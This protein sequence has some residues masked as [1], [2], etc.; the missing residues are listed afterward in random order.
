MATNNANINHITD[1]LDEA[2][3]LYYEEKETTYL[4][5]LTKV[6]ESYLT[7]NVLDVENDIL[8]QIETKF[9][10]IAQI[11]CTREEIRQSL[12]LLDIKGYKHAGFSL[13]LLTPDAIGI[14][15]SYLVDAALSTITPKIMPKRKYQKPEKEKYHVVDINYGTGNLALMVYNFSEH[16][17]RMMGMETSTLVAEYACAKANLLEADIRILNQDAL[18]L[19]ISDADIVVSDLAAYEYEDDTYNSFLYNQGVNYFPYLAIEKYLQSGHLD[20]KYIYLIDND[21]FEQKGSKIFKEYLKEHAGIQ[22]LIALPEKF[23]QSEPR[24][25]L[26]LNKH[27]GCGTNIYNLPNLEY[28]QEFMNVMNQ[29]KKS[30]EEKNSYE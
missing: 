20:T 19:C 30:L 14:I 4:G 9:N 11:E 2:T 6:I 23:F 27:I 5:C 29:I 15:C 25:I 28:E 21:F 13:D 3:M 16:P 26:V 17:L 24:A 7:G 8:T 10:E 1:L 18:H 12:L 22:A